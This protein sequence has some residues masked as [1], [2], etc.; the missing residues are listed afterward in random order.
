[1]K[2]LTVLFAAVIMALTSYAA[3]NEYGWTNG[4]DMFREFIA[5]YNTFAGA[6]LDADTCVAY[7][8]EKGFYGLTYQKTAVEGMF[9]DTAYSAKWGWLLTF[10]TDQCRAFQGKEPDMTASMMRGAIDNFFHSGNINSTAWNK[11]YDATESGNVNDF[12]AWQPAW[13]SSWCIKEVCNDYG[14]MNGEDMFRAFI[15]DYNTFAG[16][17]LDAD[18]C[19][20]YAGEKGFYGLTYQKAAVEGMFIDAAYSAKWGWLLTFLTDQC[21]AFQGKEPDMTASMMRGAIDNFFHKGAL[22]STAWNKSYDATEKGNVDDF[23]AWQ[24]YWGLTWCTGGKIVVSYE[25]GTAVTND[26]GWMNAEDMYQALAAD[27]LAYHNDTANHSTFKLASTF[28]GRGTFG[29]PDVTGGTGVAFDIQDFDLKFWSTEPYASKWEWLVSYIEN[30]DTLA[31]QTNTIRSNASYARYNLAA[32]F[33]NSVRPNWPVTADF[34]LVGAGTPSAYMPTW[35][36]AFDNPTEIGADETWVLNIPYKEGETFRGWF[37]DAAG[38]GIQVTELTSLANGQ[39]LYAVFGAYQ[40]SLAEVAAAEDDAEVYTSGV[41]VHADGK[42]VY[43]QDITGGMLLYF[44]SAP[45]VELGQRIVVSGVKATYGGAPEVKNAELKEAAAGELPTVQ[46]KMLSELLAEPLKF[47]GQRVQVN[48][49]RIAKYDSKGNPFVVSGSDTV[50]CYKM[51]IDQTEFKVGQRVNLTAVAGYYNAFR[52]VGDIAGFEKIIYQGLKDLNEYDKL[53]FVDKDGDGGAAGE[54]YTY[55]IENNWLI[56][57]NLGNWA[58]NKPN[59]VAEQCR[60]MAVKDGIIYIT[61]R[62]SNTPNRGELKLLRYDAETGEKLADLPLKDYVFCEPAADTT[63][64]RCVVDEETGISYLAE[65]YE[66]NYDEFTSAPI[67]GPNTDMHVD[68]DGN[69]LVANL[70]TEGHCFQI[71]KLTADENGVLDGGGELVVYA[72]GNSGISDF[73]F[74]Y[75]DDPAIRL[76]RFDLAGSVDGDAWIFAP[77]Q[78]SNIVYEMDITGGKWDGECWNHV[79]QNGEVAF[80]YSP[81]IA[82][83]DGGEAFYVD[84]F[85]THPALFANDGTMLENFAGIVDDEGEEVNPSAMDLLQNEDGTAPATGECGVHEFPCGGAYFLAMGAGS[86]EGAYQPYGSHLVFR[87]KNDNRHFY[88]MQRAWELSKD[89]FGANKNAQF[90]YMQCHIQKDDLTTELYLFVA[91]NGIGKYT[92]T[93]DKYFGEQETGLE[94]V[95]ASVKAG[96]VKKVMVNG[97]MFIIRDGKAFSAMGQKF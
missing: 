70:P 8:G 6:D 59:Q 58:A 89:G 10:L 27:V 43:I 81:R 31:G 52:F 61:Y 85:A 49:V 1:M 63:G 87:F 16:A 19:V 36:H 15:A 2:K 13:G 14:W 4:E 96:D 75:P 76:D 44:N 42:N 33:Q 74:R 45:A 69:I 23:L 5:D 12:L 66:W 24:P 90:N 55:S 80:S 3:C 34:T 65:G 50:Q 41:V 37:F 21:R 32:F 92:I 82:V 47:F 79:C 95:K 94:A 77:S 56:S 53:V 93:A 30:L 7:A 54:T 18:T 64:T 9:V 57:E 28:P 11:S 20:A 97:R 84:G 67:F 88:E 83:V 68:Y 48:D 71:W 26:Y 60:G 40:M 86:Y 29:A 73:A 17:D 72:G 25:L 39:T 62:A 38:Q 22:N 51:V 35:K 46:V 78:N 91:E